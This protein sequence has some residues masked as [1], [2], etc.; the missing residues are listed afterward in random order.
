MIKNEYILCFCGMLLF[1]SCSEKTKYSNNETP[2]KVSEEIKGT[3]T[4]YDLGSIIHFNDCG[5]FFE[6]DCCSG[7]LI[8]LDS[9]YYYEDHCVGSTTLVGGTIEI[10]L[11]SLILKSNG[12][13]VSEEYNWESDTDSTQQRVFI[14]D[15]ILAPHQ[16]SFAIR[17]CDEKIKL[18]NA[19]GNDTWIAFPNGAQLTER[20]ND[21]K[22]SDVFA[23]YESKI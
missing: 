17:E 9:T 20:I 6:C 11:D 4:V 22:K 23:V 13:S 15:T 2:V 12:V 19:T 8:I 3:N 21:L 18:I 7:D 16:M 5:F 1:Y 14:K 10:S